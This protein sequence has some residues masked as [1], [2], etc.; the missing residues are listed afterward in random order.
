M[1]KIQ[2]EVYLHVDDQRD[3]WGVGVATRHKNIL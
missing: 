1:G 2:T 3:E